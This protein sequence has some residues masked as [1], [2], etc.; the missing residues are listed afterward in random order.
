MR[1]QDRIALDESA[2]HY[3]AN[4]Y[5]HVANSHI[6]KETVNPYYGSEIMELGEGLKLD[7][8]KIYY[9]YRPGAELEKAAATF[10]GLPLLFE[11]H[12]DSA[13]EPQKE[14]RVGSLGTDA[15]F[16]APYL[17]NSLII[18]DAK[19]IIAI[20]NGDYKELSS[21]YRYT[22]DFTTGEFE[23][24]KYDFIMRDIVGNHVA[25]VQEGRVGRDV[26]V[27]DSQIK[28]KGENKGMDKMKELIGKLMELLSGY[29][30]EDMEPVTEEVI[31]KTFAGTEE[32]EGA[33]IEEQVTDN[34]PDEHTAMDD[35]LEAVGSIED[36]ELAEKIRALLGA[37]G[38]DEV[39]VS[40][41]GVPGE[42]KA[43]DGKAKKKTVAMD[44]DAIKKA[45]EKSMREKHAAARDCA[46]LCGE[47]V[48]PYAFDSASDI[49]KKALEL[50]G[51]DVSKY[52]PSA[53]RGMVDML[54]ASENRNAF[55]AASDSSKSKTSV[56]DKYFAG[57]DN[58]R[59]LG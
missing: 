15:A 47:I 49:Y 25:L 51:V 17:D 9:G 43:Q 28:N 39:T 27:A 44:A 12:F 56:D 33:L 26:A 3:D 21:A 14:H 13:E 30:V 59:I 36:P 6:S 1:I 23:A 2:R 37:V 42:G 57:L 10:N 38:S 35:L 52:A 11:H 4:G 50:V 32:D 34:D 55:S 45:V 48:D 24:Q 58:I 19:A 40:N 7:P 18:T 31:E 5:L 41:A 29:Q 46:P 20:E 54:K 53:Y 8:D 22:P 16:N